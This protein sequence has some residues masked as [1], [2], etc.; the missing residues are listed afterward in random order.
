[1]LVGVLAVTPN[2]RCRHQRHGAHQQERI[3]HRGLRAL[4]E[5]GLVGAPVD[6]VGAEHVSDED[7]VEQALLQSL[8]EVGPVAE[9][10]VAPGL[11]VRVAPQTGR[12]VA[13]T[14]HVER[15]EADLSGGS[16]HRRTSGSGH[17][18]EG[19]PYL[20]S[21]SAPGRILTWGTPLQ[22]GGCRPTSQG[23]ASE[24]LILLPT[25]RLNPPVG[26]NNRVT[27]RHEDWLAIAHSFNRRAPWGEGLRRPDRPR[28]L[29]GEGPP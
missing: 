17:C 21:P 16:G 27:D 20:P 26:P 1:M 24:L 28:I 14:V 6:V 4:P 15:V 13:H 19:A 2:P 18:H 23:F 12:L 22:R 5:G 8:R 25:L 10:L 7:A 11:I 3:I 9:V 29:I